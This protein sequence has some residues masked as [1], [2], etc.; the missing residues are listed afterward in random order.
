MNSRLKSII[1]A[2]QDPNNSQTYF[3]ETYL[4]QFRSRIIGVL[5]A[6]TKPTTVSQIQSTFKFPSKIFTTIAQDL[7][8]DR[9]IKGH[10]TSFSSNGTYVPETYSKIQNDYVESFLKQ[11]RYI[12]Y[13]AL[14][15]I[16]ITDVK[17]YFKKCDNLINLKSCL[18]DKTVYKQI[19][20][21][22]EDTLNDEYLIDLYTIAPS[23]LNEDD[24]T[25]LIDLF[26]SSNK[27][28]N[29]NLIL[30][31]NYVIN[32]KYLDKL[33]A[34]FNQL[35]KE[36]ADNDLKDGL[37]AAYFAGKNKD[38]KDKN[39]GGQVLSKK[40]ERRK[41][42]VKSKSGGG[43]QGREVKTRSTKKKYN[44]K[45][46]FPDDEDY[47]LDMDSSQNLGKQDTLRL[48]NSDE[49][50]KHL[51]KICQQQNDLSEELLEQ[52]AKLLEPILNSLYADIA[53]DVYSSS[54]TV[55]GSMIKK[56]HSELQNTTQQLYNNIFMFNKGLEHVSG[57]FFF[58]FENLRI[59]FVFKLSDKNPFAMCLWSMAI[60]HMLDPN[61][62]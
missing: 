4:D 14:N 61:N 11:N 12:E 32:R 19:E 27:K 20:S 52:I 34:E 46:E 56:T 39:D 36:K 21:G 15:R 48:M 18:I 8:K 17:N 42:N 57:K 44:K 7:I 16:G 58:N 38:S 59:N 2:V 41:Q 23:V 51:T 50:F 47:G 35:M 22:I 55:S 28:Q 33:K 30:V 60:G 62:L 5:N 10:F 29:D 6:T 45:D 37:L 1:N 9:L 54:L 3:T 24:F 43:T 26:L 49:I 25:V 53:R 31:A 13:D 40:E